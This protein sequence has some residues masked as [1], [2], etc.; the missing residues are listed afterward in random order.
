M[1]KVI[2]HTRLDDGRYKLLLMGGKRAFIENELSAP[3]PF[4]TALVT[5]MDDLAYDDHDGHRQAVLFEKFM[6]HLRNS[7]SS[8]Q[9][10]D[11]LLRRKVSLG[12][13]TDI[14]AS[15]LD[16]LPQRKYELLEQTSAIRRAE[17]LLGELTDLEE[18]SARTSGR[19]F[20]PDF[21]AN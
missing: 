2:A 12:L 7:L 13:L 3:Q 6:R 19:G 10:L 4:R 1:G 21:S 20:P 17:M 14:V 18:T 15:V 9:Q 16:L 5:L 8:S 11:E